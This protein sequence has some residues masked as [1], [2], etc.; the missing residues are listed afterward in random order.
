M[1]KLICLILS[2]VSFLAVN[3]QIATTYNFEDA[4][5]NL[6]RTTPYTPAIKRMF[7]DSVTSSLPIL[8]PPAGSIWVNRESPFKN[9]TIEELVKKVFVEG[10]DCLVSNVTFKGWGWNQNT[11]TWTP[12]AERSLAYFSHGTLNGLGMEEGILLA[13]GDVL[14][15]EGPNSATNGMEGGFSGTDSNLSALIPGYSINTVSV[16]EFDLIPFTN[17]LHFDYIF[18]S[19]EYPEFSCSNYN[20]VFGF[21]ISGPGITGTRNIA[22]IP[23]TNMPVSIANIHPYTSSYCLAQ[24]AQYYVDGTGNLYTEFDGHTTM[25]TTAATTVIPG[26]TYHLK[27]AIANVGDYKLGSGVFLRAGSLDLGLAL[28]NHGND[29]QG[30]DNVF[31]GC[32]NNQFIINLSPL[33]NGIS[34]IL[35]Y[36]GTAVNDIVSPDGS[37]LPATVTIP[38]GTSEF[39]IPYKV[40]SPVT[41]NGGTFTITITTNSILCQNQEIINKTIYVYDK[42]TNPQFNITTTC[43]NNSGTLGVVLTEGSPNV[44]FSI[45]DENIW[46]NVSNYSVAIPV[47]AHTIILKDSGSC[48]VDTFNINV[49][50]K[51]SSDTTIYDTI[52]VHQ[53]YHLNGFNVPEQDNVGVFYFPLTLQNVYG[54]DSTVYLIL[55]VL[56][57]I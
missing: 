49:P 7:V 37:P 40:N 33:A 31:E 26:S 18:A 34:L 10:G 51:S 15:A 50:Y 25:L 5:E 52:Y 44:K 3:A 38:A 55:T 35:Q 4:T 36:S 57:I 11:Q 45:D 14:E 56:D 6:R 41:A 8:A 13:T 17:S 43:D 21:F 20:D 24:N 53:S 30:M 29:F 32:G 39:S 12:N 22:L 2:S 23:N 46:H 28:V 19:E 16:L 9:Y 27:L 42:I 54:C 1:K 47:G 48:S